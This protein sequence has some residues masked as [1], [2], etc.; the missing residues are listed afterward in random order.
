MSID[1]FTTAVRPCWNWSKKTGQAAQSD[2]LVLRVRC[3][4]D[5][6]CVFGRKRLQQL[7]LSET[8]VGIS[9]PSAMSFA[10]SPSLAVDT[11]C[12]SSVPSGC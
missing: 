3:F 11:R 6:G 9:Q 12:G 1:L 4:G 8:P 5:L 10:G 2:R 7:P